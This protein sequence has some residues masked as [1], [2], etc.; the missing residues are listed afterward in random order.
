MFTGVRPGL[1]CGGGMKKKQ[2][3]SSTQASTVQAGNPR[4]S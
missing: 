2:I 1:G 3:S 4:L